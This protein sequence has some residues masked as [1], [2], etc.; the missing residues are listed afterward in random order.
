M[1]SSG[2]AT[3][4]TFESI[5]DTTIAT[6]RFNDLNVRIG[7]ILNF[8]IMEDEATDTT[9]TAVTTVL[10][11]ITEVLIV[12]IVAQS[13]I[14]A[15]TNPWDFLGVLDPVR[16]LNRFRPIINSIK[17]KL[18]YDA[19]DMSTRDLPNVNTRTY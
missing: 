17:I 15:T 13:K 16:I 2:Y 18:G 7:E 5:W 9:D 12:E 10:A 8:L 11:H 3:E 19:W 4:A 1:T 14:N 6:A